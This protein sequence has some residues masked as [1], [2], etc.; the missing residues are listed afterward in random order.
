MEIRPLQIP[1]IIENKD[2]LIKLIYQG[3]AGHPPVIEDPEDT[4]NMALTGQV[5][6]WAFIDGGIK[7][8]C[9]T[10]I[11][12]HAINAFGFAGDGV[13]KHAPE[14]LDIVS[15]FAKVAGIKHIQICTIPPV[16]KKILKLP[17]SEM[18]MITVEICA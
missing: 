18:A 9:C 6:I 15:K 11:L 1:E 17:Y 14:L 4:Y 2:H 10:I 16:A 8:I 5:Q 7:G 3:L 12:P 13:L